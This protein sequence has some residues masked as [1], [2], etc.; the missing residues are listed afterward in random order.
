MSNDFKSLNG[1]QFALIKFMFLLFIRFLQHELG[2]K[3]LS[4]E[5]NVS[6]NLHYQIII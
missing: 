2:M 1:M 3:D 6:Q 5:K 4:S